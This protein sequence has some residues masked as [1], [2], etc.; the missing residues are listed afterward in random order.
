MY[1]L[2]E[3]NGYREDRTRSWSR[4]N[5]HSPSHRRRR[6]F[7]RRILPAAAPP[8]LPQLEPAAPPT[9]PPPPPRRRR[10]L[11]PLRRRARSRSPQLLFLSMNVTVISARRIQC[12]ICFVLFCY[13]SFSIKLCCV[14]SFFSRRKRGFVVLFRIVRLYAWIEVWKVILRV[15]MGNE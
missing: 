9:S 6:F 11:L 1:G 8:L 2:K 3:P 13:F 15:S 12:P 10:V 5:N 14:W 4:P 7:L